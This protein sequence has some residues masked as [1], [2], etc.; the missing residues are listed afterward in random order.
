MAVDPQRIDGLAIVV[1]GIDLAAVWIGIYR[2]IT[3]R[4]AVTGIL[5]G[6]C[7]SSPRFNLQ[8]GIRRLAD[9]RDFAVT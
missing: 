9:L 3:G 7:A 4:N 1:P 6:G 8:N 5:N 2:D